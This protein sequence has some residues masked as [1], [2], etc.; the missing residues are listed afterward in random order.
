MSRAEPSFNKLEKNLNDS[1]L[2]TPLAISFA[3]T[4]MDISHDQMDRVLD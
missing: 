4:S 1:D 3:K 2:C